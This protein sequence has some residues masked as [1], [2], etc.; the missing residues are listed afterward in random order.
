[1][2]PRAACKNPLKTR[3]AMDININQAEVLPR[4][5]IPIA[6]GLENVYGED[7][8]E[9]SHEVT[10]DQRDAELR[11]RAIDVDEAGPSTGIKTESKIARK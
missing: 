10:R 11:K 5:G 9:F 2:V 7:E 3:D 6:A 4:S 1:M 8:V